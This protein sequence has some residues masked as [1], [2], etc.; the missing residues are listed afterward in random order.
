MADLIER[1]AED[2]ATLHAVDGGM[3]FG[4]VLNMDMPVVTETLRYFSGWADK[5]TGK[6]VD[7]PH[8]FGYTRREPLGVCVAIVPWNAPLMIT[9]WKLAPALATGNVLILKTPELA[10]L[11]G[12]KLG[13]LIAEAG[14]P[15]GTVNILC[16]EGKTAGQALAE[17]MSVRK[18]AFTGSTATGRNILRA[19]ANSNL[20]RVTLELGGKGPSIV[21]ADANRMNALFWTMVGSSANNGQICALG[22]RIYVQDSIYEEFVQ[23]FQ[24]MAKEMPSV[25]GNPLEQGTSKGPIVNKTQHDK[26]LSY[27]KKGQEEGAKVLL[28]GNG[29][30]VGSSGF[31]ENTV[32]VDV[33]EDMAIVKEEIFGPVATIHRFSTEKEVIAKAN[34]SELG[35]SAAV[36]TDNTSRANRVSA[37]LETG[38]VTVNSWGMLTPNMPFGGMKQS[39]FGRDMGEDALEGWTTLKAVKHWVFDDDES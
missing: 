36:F 30:A 38:Q 8:G 26:I 17:H 20:K 15:P 31:V 32:F 9:S 23:Q 21:F 24:A 4:D 25:M 2:F 27:L 18:I 6:A 34:A 22:S 28:G 11:Y 39:G 19:S 37:A 12:Q 3:V 5:I 16:G 33:K 29:A 1:D 7:I 13:E 10:P 35:L 14:F